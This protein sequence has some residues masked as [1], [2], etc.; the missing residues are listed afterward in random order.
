M[1]LKDFIA[2]GLLALVS[3]PVILL[4]VLMWTG[5]VRLAFGPED[6]SSS[7]TRERLQVR[8]ED[9][10]GAMPAEGLPAAAPANHM[11]GALGLREVELDRREAEVQRE[12]ARL[13]ELKAE[14]Q[15][16]REEIDADRKRIEA[17]LAGKDSMETARLRVLAAT[18]S[19]MKADQ[20]A[21]ILVGLDD[22]LATNVLRTITDDKPRAKLLAAVGKIDAGRAATLARLLRSVAGAS[23]P[24]AKA[25][26][27]PK[28]APTDSTKGAKP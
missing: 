21:K 16:L 2:L 15:R 14:D 4:G 6:L 24:A 19:N 27:G 25:P 17:L 20:A 3:F 8:P 28:P 1:R 22:V 18:F 11:E 9:L 12:M 13:G 26:S 10:E 7:A 5:N 23:E